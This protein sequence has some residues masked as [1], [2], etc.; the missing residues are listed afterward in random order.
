[1]KGGEESVPGDA[2]QQHSLLQQNGK[3]PDIPEHMQPLVQQQLNALEMR[4][5]VWQGNIWPGQSMQWEI[6]EQDQSA[7]PGRDEELRQWETVI[8]L[9]LP[10]LGEVSAK[11]H[12]GNRGLSL[13]LG[14]GSS[15]TRLAMSNAAARL[16]EALA[17]NGISIINMQVVQHE[18][19]Q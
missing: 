5:M 6:H 12:F 2:L 7:K 1:M 18:P 14:A 16:A 4:Q 13:V 9:N 10:A 17:G 11:L 19:A 8:S 15:A 3:I